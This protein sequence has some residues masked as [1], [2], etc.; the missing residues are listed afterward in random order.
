MQP[1]ITLGR[2]QDLPEDDN[3]L[4]KRVVGRRLALSER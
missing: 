1:A 4:V 3:F 2:F